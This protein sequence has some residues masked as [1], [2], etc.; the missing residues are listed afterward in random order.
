MFLMAQK[1]VPGSNEQA[2]YLTAAVLTI[3]GPTQLLLEVCLHALLSNALYHSLYKA[4]SH[5]ETLSCRRYDTVLV[6]PA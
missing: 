6:C 2:L 5:D 1:P 3:P 4:R